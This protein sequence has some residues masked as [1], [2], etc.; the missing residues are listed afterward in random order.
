[1]RSGGST[2][3]R[4]R[5]NPH[6]RDES[7]RSAAPRARRSASW[8]C[9]R[10]A[11]GA[12]RPC[13]GPGGSSAARVRRRHV[14]AG[15]V[16][17]RATRDRSTRLRQ[18]RP[19]DGDACA[20]SFAVAS[21]R[22]ASRRERRGI[23]R[24]RHVARTARTPTCCGVASWSAPA[25]SAQQYRCE[26]VP[27]RDDRVEPRSRRPASRAKAARAACHSDVDPDLPR[28]SSRRAS[29]STSST[30]RAS[31]RSSSYDPAGRSV[32]VSLAADRYRA[33]R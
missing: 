28:S 15:A 29:P 13:A 33:A 3:S 10:S 22:R 16:G 2:R 24:R 7:A 8:S 31:A 12:A 5:Y 26:D 20:A 14:A 18:P 23:D 1:M 19:D 11:S 32:L 21:G 6:E 9:G 4:S 30:R 17:A 27:G 25:S